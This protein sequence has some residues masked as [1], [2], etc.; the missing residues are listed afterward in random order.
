MINKTLYSY[1]YLNGMIISFLRKYFNYFKL[2]AVFIVLF[3]YTTLN[4]ENYPKRIVSLA[5]SVT[6]NL[7]SLGAESSVVGITIYCQKGKT[8]KEVIGTMLEPSIEKIVTLKPDLAIAT[9][10]G[11]P[12]ALVEKIRSVGIDVLVIE[13][14]DTFESICDNFLIIAKHIGKKD[15]SKEIIN[16]TKSYMQSIQKKLENVEK[17][18]IFWEIDDKPLITT[19]KNSFINDF[20]KFTHSSNIFDD[21][22]GRFPRVSWEE[23]VKRDPDIIVIAVMTN[24]EKIKNRYETEFRHLK[25]V[26]N[27]RIHVIN[28]LDIF[29]PTPE[30]FKKGVKILSQIA[31]PEVFNE[32]K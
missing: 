16:N 1:S 9:K 27:N 15:K 13:N 32:N 8:A 18:S 19:G 31:H 4:G 11:N 20:N 12:K 30:T 17:P 7:Y 10:E 6:K 22:M 25:A 5:P 14:D 21:L 24:G 23:V 29:T 26:K 3:F 2:L 28:E